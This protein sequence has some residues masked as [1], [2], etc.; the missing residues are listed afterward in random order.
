MAIV[1]LYIIVTS[2]TSNRWREGPTHVG[3][4]YWGLRQ[5]EESYN[6]G[7]PNYV[8]DYQDE[9]QPY[10]YTHNVLIFVCV[11][12]GILI[13]LELLVCKKK[14]PSYFP[15]SFGLIT[16]LLLF[17][18][19]EH[20]KSA[21][22]FEH[23]E[24][25]I[26]LGKAYNHCWYA[27]HFI[28]LSSILIVGKNRPNNHNKIKNRNEK[29]KTVIFS[30]ISLSISAFGLFCFSLSLQFDL[31]FRRLFIILLII[32]I[33]S[34]IFGIIAILLKRKK[35]RTSLM[36]IRLEIISTWIGVIFIVC[37]VLSFLT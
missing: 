22:W 28:L 33:I 19:M 27:I 13:L 3:D 20:F 17:I 31:S 32:G 15:V 26:P 7:R 2:L 4:Q 34:S 10:K 12:I 36:D 14:L 23:W 29:E 35:K 8:R 1:A 21:S 30:I 9:R 24:G 6:D 11:M 5:Y 37:S 18:T 25:C 16:G